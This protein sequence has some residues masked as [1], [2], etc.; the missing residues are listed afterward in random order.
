MAGAR[1][2]LLLV[3]LGSDADAKARAQG[4]YRLG[5]SSDIYKLMPEGLAF[6]QVNLS[7]QFLK[8]RQPTDPGRYACV[9]NL[10]TDPDQHPQVLESA[11][12]LLDGYRGRLIN[13]P[14]AVQ[15]T[16]RDQVAKRLSGIAGLRVPQAIRLHD[17]KPGAAEA[18]AE[19]TDLRFPLIV[20]LAGTHTGKII[21][22]VDGPDALEAACAGPGRFILTEFV[23]FRSP[24]G[25][26]R[27]YRMWSFGGAAIFRHMIVADDWNVHV[28]MRHS[29]MASRP[30]LIEE[31]K[32]LLEQPHGAFPDIVHQVFAAVQQRIGLDFFGMDFGLDRQGQVVLFEA[33]ATMSFFPLERP[34]HFTYLAKIRQPAQVA[35]RQMI[36]PPA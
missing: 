9:L 23:D 29:F 26:Y 36:F 8:S 35:V 3:I 4:G 32:R 13:P 25:L 33:N 7:Q 20:R 31:E 16:T 24:D 2:P 34:P 19:K 18:A 17:P 21:G 15:R 27:K 6:D 28:S 22:V 12:T 10:I 5:G 1:T 14:E 11:R 30:A